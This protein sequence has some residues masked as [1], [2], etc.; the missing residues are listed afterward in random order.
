MRLNG[1]STFNRYLYIN[2]IHSKMTIITCKIKCQRLQNWTT[3]N[4][5]G[6]QFAIIST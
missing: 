4:Y 6:L 2:P 1:K 3:K 5:Q